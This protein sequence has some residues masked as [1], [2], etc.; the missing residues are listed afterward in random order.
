M[1]ITEPDEK[2]ENNNIILCDLNMSFVIPLQLPKEK[3]SY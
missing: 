3:Y 1:S 2:Y